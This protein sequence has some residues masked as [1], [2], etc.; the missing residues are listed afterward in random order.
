[1][2]LRMR[3]PVLVHVLGHHGVQNPRI[4]QGCILHVE[5]QRMTCYLDTFHYDSFYSFLHHFFYSTVSSAAAA[6]EK[7][8]D[9]R[10][11]MRVLMTLLKSIDRIVDAIAKL[12]RCGV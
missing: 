6:V 2:G 5:I 4:D 7:E 8:A 9:G 12:L 3:V 11:L 1:M 10:A